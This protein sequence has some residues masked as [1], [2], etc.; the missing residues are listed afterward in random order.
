MQSVFCSLSGQSAS[1]NVKN[2]FFCTDK[3]KLVHVFVFQVTEQ[4]KGGRD[5]EI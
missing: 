2:N 4:S 5:A 1:N 3:F